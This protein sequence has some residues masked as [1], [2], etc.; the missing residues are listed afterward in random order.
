MRKLEFLDLLSKKSGLSKTT[1]KEV[2]R[3]FNSILSENLIVDKNIS[4]PYIGIFRLKEI[5]A[6]DLAAGT[7]VNLNWK[8]NQS[9]SNAR[10]A[11]HVDAYKKLTFTFNHAL[12]L[13]LIGTRA[14]KKKI[15]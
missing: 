11:M 14:I 3:S 4:V 10:P 9:T 8:T 7:Y 6:H 12:K 5:P 2:L 1:L 13:A 15:K